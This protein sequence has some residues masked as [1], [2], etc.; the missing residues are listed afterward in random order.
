MTKALAGRT[1]LD[2]KREQELK[3][4]NKGRATERSQGGRASK[5]KHHRK[6]AT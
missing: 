3:N 6:S 2:T 1:H 5:K 4:T